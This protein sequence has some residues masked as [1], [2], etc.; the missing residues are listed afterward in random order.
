MERT[1][2]I[3]KCLKDKEFF[4]PSVNP[5]IN[6]TKEDIE[7]LCNLG[8]LYGYQKG[9]NGYFVSS[10]KC[11]NQMIELLL[12][13]QKEITKQELNTT[14]G[15]SD[16][17]IRKLLDEGKLVTIKRGV[18]QSNVASVHIE[19]EMLPSNLAVTEEMMKA[20]DANDLSKVLKLL[21]ETNGN[22]F[23]ELS[24]N[25]WKWVMTQIL[26]N[27]S[28]KEETPKQE[29]V[30]Q[31]PRELDASSTIPKEEIEKKE[32]ETI[33]IETEETQTEITE[34]NLSSTM[35]DE[36]DK[37][38][39]E[40]EPELDNLEY[41]PTGLPLE[42]LYGLYLKNKCHDPKLAKEF[43]LEYKDLCEEKNIPFNYLDLKAIN[44]FIEDFNI[45]AEQLSQERELKMK[46]YDLRNRE[47]S[48]AGFDDLE[49][50]LNQ[51]YD[52]YQE[53][54]MISVLFRGDYQAKMGN[55]SE[56]LKIYNSL[57]QKELWN[58]TI[59]H[60]IA[61]LFQEM[62]K[63]DQMIQML[64]KSL[65]FVPKD[66][67][68]RSQLAFAYI[69]K[70]KFST[71]RDLTDLENFKNQSQ[72]G[73]CIRAII[74]KLGNQIHQY[75]RYGRLIDSFNLSKRIR[76][77]IETVSLEL[78]YYQELY[79]QLGAYYDLDEEM[80]TG[81]YFLQEY[82]DEVYDITIDQETGVICPGR[83]EEYVKNFQT[84][85]PMDEEL[86]LY[87]AAAKIMFTHKWPKHGEHYLKLV[88]HAH[89][90]NPAIQREYEQLVKNKKLY[91]NK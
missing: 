81:N 11:M 70:E 15:I 78:E 61:S 86:L 14:F 74:R 88:A 59:Y 47:L 27:E 20:I 57:L 12:N 77:K 38:N 65:S 26:G 80:M 19:N 32:L 5:D 29:L 17:R 24:R 49:T 75:K 50:T 25:L 66:D 21:E 53:R 90:V 60:R 56:A 63:V 58:P 31:N 44:R 36:L 35:S 71:V 67:Y 45:S 43:L 83:L 8:I 52:L 64:E 16:Y 1:V 51:F 34:E 91:L 10:K 42:E 55:Y 13:S 62:G 72:Y 85:I 37:K 87:I 40:L 4:I 84:S 3:L 54:G 6:I 2:E 30:E 7:N 48:R 46:I 41:I 23:I 39:L 89:P 28:V 22:E 79:S 76:K 18:Y 33:S 9:I 68:W 69:D 82:E 73:L